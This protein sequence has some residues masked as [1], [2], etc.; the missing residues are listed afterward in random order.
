MKQLAMAQQGHLAADN[1]GQSLGDIFSGHPQ[2]D[3]HLISAAGLVHDV[4]NMI[5]VASSA[6]TLLARTQEMPRQK[7]E[8]LLAQAR[9][10]LDSGGSL[11]RQ[12]L[13][14]IGYLSQRV[15][16]VSI[17]ACLFDLRDL[18]DGM[19]NIEFGSKYRSTSICQKCGASGRAC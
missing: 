4:G 1:R 3:Q 16:D 9:A 19:G 14:R 17:A 2:G 8:P 5:Q 11:V 7:R 6:L 13:D 15:E 12:G 18:V 10:S